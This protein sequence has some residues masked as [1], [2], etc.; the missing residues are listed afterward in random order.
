MTGYRRRSGK[1]E[2]K[3]QKD[4]RLLKERWEGYTEG[5]KR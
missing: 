1:V 2:L 4:T 5:K 3:V